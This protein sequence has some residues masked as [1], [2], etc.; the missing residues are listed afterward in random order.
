MRT[1]LI[2]AATAA[3][4]LSLG[5]ASAEPPD[6]AFSQAHTEW[7]QAKVKELLAPVYARGLH[8]TDEQYSEAWCRAAYF[9]KLANPGGEARLDMETLLKFRRLQW[10]C[11]QSI[12][13]APPL[14]D[15]PNPKP[16]PTRSDPE[17]ESQGGNG[18]V[19]DFMRWHPEEFTDPTGLS[20]EDYIRRRLFWWEW[21]GEG[22]DL[23]K[24]IEDEEKAGED[25]LGGDGPGLLGPDALEQTEEAMRKAV[26]EARR[27]HDEAEAAEI[28]KARREWA[29]AHPG[30]D[31]DYDGDLRVPGSPDT[32]TYGEWRYDPEDGQGPYAIPFE[33]LTPE[34]QQEHF[35]WER[36]T[37]DGSVDPL[38]AVQDRQAAGSVDP[39]DRAAWASAVRPI[40]VGPN[41]QVGS[42]ARL[43]DQAVGAIAGALGMRGGDDDGPS[44]E[45][46][47][48]DP[49]EMQAF[50]DP[51]TG[52]SMKVAA[53]RNGD[54]VTVCAQVAQSPDQGTFQAAYLDDMQGQQQA[55]RDVDIC[56][57]YGQWRL[58]VGWTRSTY[59]NGALTSRETGGWTRQGQLDMPGL[60]PGSD[61]IWKRL[62][63]SNASRGAQMARFRFTVPRQRMGPNG[64][65]VVIHITRPNQD[66][67]TTTPFAMVMREGPEGFS[68]E[69]VAPSGQ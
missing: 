53:R 60:S 19:E 27:R 62:G 37:A 49:N 6:P 13:R 21:M 7:M 24:A 34:Q 41:S 52:V 12:R 33:R 39:L 15:E 50:G 2:A 47:R 25:F 36:R 66:P 57:L 69:R 32:T 28:E 11:G 17:D 35:E 45:N 4:L 44:V 68:F 31:G 58:S 55:P 10:A 42:G 26:E 3:L 29:A 51:Q 48:F 1:M 67:V 8:P 20:E 46:C 38:D 63:F 40:V 16:P 5:P 61:A 30:Q 59:T 43:R 9:W 18:A 64:M 65:G 14:P 22:R 23:S 56:R 54:T